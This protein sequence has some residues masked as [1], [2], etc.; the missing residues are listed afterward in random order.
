M[1]RPAQLPNDARD[2]FRKSCGRCAQLPLFFWRKILVGQWRRDW[3][4]NA[5]KRLAGSRV[6]AIA[7]V[8][9]LVEGGR[10]FGAALCS[11]RLFK[12]LYPW[13]D[14]GLDHL[15]DR[16]AFICWKEPCGVL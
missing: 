4:L 16:D 14:D 1:K 9:K 6:A 13:I 12:L 15:S 10:K 8:G 11:N 5:Y 3:T 2:P 7:A